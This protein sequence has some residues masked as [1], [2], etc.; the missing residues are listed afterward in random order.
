MLH[1]H[2]RHQQT[3]GPIIEA[4]VRHKRTARRN[5]TVDGARRTAMD[6]A[7]FK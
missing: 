5:E 6:A 2:V 7:A 4:T 3:A 1:V